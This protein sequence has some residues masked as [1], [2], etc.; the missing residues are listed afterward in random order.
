MEI[1]IAQQGRAMAQSLL[2]GAAAGVAYDLIRVLRVRIR[3]RGLGAVL[4]L[5]FWVG[6]T[7][8]LFAWSLEAWGGWVRLYG[9][10]GLLV[11]GGIYFC[12]LSPP[13]LDL[14]YRG[15]DVVEFL[16]RLVVLPMKWVFF[17]LKKI[18]IFAKNSFHY[19]RKWYKIRQPDWKAKRASR[20]KAERR[21]GGG[22]RAGEENGT[23]D[24]DRGAGP[25]DLH[26]HGIA[27][28]ARSA[29]GLPGRGGRVGGTGGT[30]PAGERGPDRGPAK[31]RRPRR[32]GTGGP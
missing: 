13:V 18:K 12:L 11:G 28:S 8:A 23:F 31:Q 9:A 22:C 32:T 16:V 3:V 26:G 24:Q 2:L 1:S 10:A 30:G 15:A 17:L 14:A 6:L 20:R 29:A 21:N 7:L 19:V 27:E 4:D 5:L 25:V